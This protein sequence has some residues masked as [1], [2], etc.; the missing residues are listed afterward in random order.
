MGTADQK[1]KCVFEFNRYRED[2]SI[3]TKG[4]RLIHNARE[5]YNLGMIGLSQGATGPTFP[6]ITLLHQ[7]IEIYF[8][9]LLY[10]NNIDILNHKH[11]DLRKLYEATLEHYPSVVD[12][13]KNEEF[14]GLLDQFNHDNF[15][16]YI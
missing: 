10:L 1:N 9:T 8:K 12:L 5:T 13:T 16:I 6:A 4:E 15:K 2:F 11:H 3:R 14:L 7:S